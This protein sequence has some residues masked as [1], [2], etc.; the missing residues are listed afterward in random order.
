[1]SR[2]YKVRRL[3]GTEQEDIEATSVADAAKY[4]A[5]MNHDA[6]DVADGGI[7]LVVNDGDKDYSVTVEVVIEWDA[8]VNGLHQEEESSDA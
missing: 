5:V 3:D 1:M 6:E 2:S 7:E 8:F 4:F